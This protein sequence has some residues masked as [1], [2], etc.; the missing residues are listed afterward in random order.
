MLPDPMAE[1]ERSLNVLDQL[2][3][4]I[5]V[6]PYKRDMA[7]HVSQVAHDLL[8]ERYLGQTY[9]YEVDWHD[10]ETR[11]RAVAVLVN[12]QVISVSGVIQAQSRRKQLER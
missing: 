3:A 6:D 2:V 5:R 12:Q 8:H 7:L 9:G 1:L 10:L 4:S 11:V